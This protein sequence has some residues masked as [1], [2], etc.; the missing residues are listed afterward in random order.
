MEFSTRGSIIYVRGC[1]II[2]LMLV[3]PAAAQNPKQKNDY[4]RNIGLCNQLD[5]ASLQAR[6]DGCTALIDAGQ[7]TTSVLAIAYNNRGNAYTAKA[8]Y[9]RAIQDFDESIKLNPTYA[10][11][12]AAWPTGAKP[13]TIPNF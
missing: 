7:G 8:D 3:S 2:L 5:R 10:K 1:I 11:P 13:A 4:V 6:I 12:S 9:D